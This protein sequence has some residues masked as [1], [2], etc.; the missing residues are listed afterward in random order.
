M[1]QVRIC[2]RAAFSNQIKSIFVYLMLKRTTTVTDA[3]V[4][5]QFWVYNV[6]WTITSWQLIRF[7]FT[8][9]ML[10]KC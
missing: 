3:K 2:K 7:R 5:I 6:S 1:K 8:C 10:Q 4:V 9:V